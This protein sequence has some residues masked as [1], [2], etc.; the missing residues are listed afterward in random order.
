M[1]RGVTLSDLV[2]R[3]RAE[4]GASVTPQTGLQELP[5]LQ[6]LLQRNQQAL[7]DAYD[8]PFL[9]AYRD[10]STQAG[11]RYYDFPADM[12][13]D[14]VDSVSFKWSGIWNR[15]D[16]GVTEEDY[17]QLDP[18]Q[19]ASQ[20]SFTI[21]GGSPGGGSQITNV[22][23]NGVDV[24]GVPVSFVTDGVTTAAAVAAQINAF[25]SYPD[26]SA[27]A[28]G[29]TVNI[30]GLLSDGD[31]ANG[32]AVSPTVAGSVTVADINVMSNGVSAR[33]NDP[34]TKWQLI[35]VGNGTQIELWPVP[36]S[37]SGTFRLF[38]KRALKPLVAD[39]DVCDLD[40]ILILL[41]CKME[42]LAGKK[43]GQLAQQAF[44]ARLN[45]MKTRFN[46]SGS[47]RMGGGYDDRIKRPGTVIRISS[48]ASASP[49]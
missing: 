23:V 13:P 33:R 6:Q 42:K 49:T 14:N 15:V 18:N 31:Q 25:T 37:P 20:G 27:I 19:I 1:A 21:T 12:P 24:L 44:T 2:Y 34:V 46:K 28:D 35:D 32:F 47:F 41:A 5:Q 3:L 11:Q 43:D 4:I 39:T 22:L 36:A 16:E 29:L 40:D 38:G 45:I 8:W 48:T 7:F 10:I 9:Q 30:L 26:Y 17:N